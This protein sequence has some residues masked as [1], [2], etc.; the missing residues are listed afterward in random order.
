MDGWTHGRK[1]TKGSIRGP[2]GPKKAIDCGYENLWLS[3]GM[4]L[5][6]DKIF[7]VTNSQ[8]KV[9]R[10]IRSC[11]MKL[12]CV[13]CTSLRLFFSSSKLKLNLSVGELTALYW[14]Y[15]YWPKIHAFIGLKV[16]QRSGSWSYNFCGTYCRHKRRRS[17]NI[18]WLADFQNRH[19]DWSLIISPSVNMTVSHCKGSQ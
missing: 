15:L 19:L 9:R 16:C 14:I 11:W 5:I 6:Y 10:P 1:E 17:L 7:F 12:A 8:G 3:Y 13:K 4:S 18:S 2:H